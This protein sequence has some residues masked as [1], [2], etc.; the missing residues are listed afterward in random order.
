M[1]YRP[2][3]KD[4]TRARLLEVGGA[5]AKKDGFSTTGVDRLMAAVGLTSGAFYSHF[6]SKAELLEAIVENELTRSLNLFANKT[7]QQVITALE[8]YLSVSH[9]NNPA[10]GCAL[11]SLSAEVA[12]SNSAT[13]QTFERMMLQLKAAVQVHAAD[14]NAAWATI[15]QVVG[16]VMIARAMATEGSRKSLLAAVMH[17]AREMVVAEK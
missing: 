7:D 6:R 12:R 5:L 3:H 4:S 2:E 10:E 1:R 13:K 11:T 9:I 15:A 8:S 14:E 16:A 17:H